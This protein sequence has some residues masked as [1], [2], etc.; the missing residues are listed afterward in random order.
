MQALSSESKVQDL[1]L[2]C[3]PSPQE[4]L[5]SDHAPKSP[6][7][8]TGS[9]QAIPYV[10]KNGLMHSTLKSTVVVMY[11]NRNYYS[12]PISMLANFNAKKTQPSKASLRVSIPCHMLLFPA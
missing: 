12:G 10:K 3:V 2:S 5:Q 11:L 4:A 8:Q 6:Q 9:G 1:L 7:T